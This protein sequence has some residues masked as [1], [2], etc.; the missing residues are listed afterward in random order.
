MVHAHWV[1]PP[2]GSSLHDDDP[3][4]RRND[5]SGLRPVVIVKTKENVFGP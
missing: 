3:E 2:V 4:V 5:I 1:F